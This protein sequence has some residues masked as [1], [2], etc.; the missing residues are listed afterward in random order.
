M[1][2]WQITFT[3]HKTTPHRNIHPGAYVKLAEQ[4]NDKDG[5]HTFVEKGYATYELAQKRAQ[6]LLKDGEFSAECEQYEVMAGELFIRRGP[7]HDI[8]SN[9][10][11]C[12]LM[13]TKATHLLGD[14]SREEPE[15]CSV[16][17]EDEENYYGMW[18][19]GLG[20]IGVQFPK[21][22]TRPPTDIEKE[23][24]ESRKIGMFG[25]QSG[26]KSYD[27]PSVKF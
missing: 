14:L 10:A 1:K 20:F 21:T 7:N 24:W 16:Y 23:Y 25:S 9:M 15:P 8:E 12:Y 17:A 5:Q 2:L 19:L 26:N 6:Q 22:T 27:V 3:H 11:G 18:V 4:L 13:A